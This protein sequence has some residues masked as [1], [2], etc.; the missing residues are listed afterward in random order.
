VAYPT[1]VNKSKIYLPLLNIKLVL[2]KIFLKAV[3]QESEGFAY[4][5][6]NFPKIA[7]TKV[8]FCWSSN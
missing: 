7:V 1:L 2:I 8:N 3:G 5:L 4:L 6:Q